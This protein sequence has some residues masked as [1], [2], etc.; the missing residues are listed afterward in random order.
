MYENIKE[1]IEMSVRWE[2]CLTTHRRRRKH[3][4]EIDDELMA[5]K[6][7]GRLCDITATDGYVVVDYNRPS[8]F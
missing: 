6:A 2:V 3:F 8:L 4:G 7:S 5:V 1:M